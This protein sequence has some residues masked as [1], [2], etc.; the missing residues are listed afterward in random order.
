M[1]FSSYLVG[2]WE[3]HWIQPNEPAAYT[4]LQIINPVVHPQEP[5]YVLVVFF[6]M[7][8]TFLRH[9][10]RQLKPNAM[11]EIRVSDIKDRPVQG[12]GVVKIFSLNRSYTQG[13]QPIEGIVGFQRHLLAGVL[14]T[15]P[16]DPEAA[17]SEAP[18]AAV[19]TQHVPP[20]W[21]YVLSL[22]P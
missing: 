5:P 19:P 2:S 21:D 4:S 15:S 16:P 9:L 8:G 3:N 18:L 20:E 14:P 7:N 11:W 6:D 17:F 10:E 12:K 13:G 22:L 1:S